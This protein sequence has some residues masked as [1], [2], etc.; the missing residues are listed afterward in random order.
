MASEKGLAAIL[1]EDDKPQ[2]VRLTAG[3]EDKNNGFLVETEHQLNEYFEGKRES[4]SVKLDFVGTDFQK[5]C[6]EG[7]FD[8]PLWGDQ[9]LW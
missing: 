1:W 7:A 6:L 3:S 4:F 8:Y 5:K 9:K 2:R